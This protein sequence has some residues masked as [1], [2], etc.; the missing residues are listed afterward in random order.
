MVDQW[1]FDA[2]IAGAIV[3]GR[4]LH[5]PTLRAIAENS[6]GPISD[7]LWE[8]LEPKWRWH[9]AVSTEEL[10]RASRLRP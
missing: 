2:G 6:L 10:Q 1:T 5:I 3:N 9:D 4:I 8:Q 7:K